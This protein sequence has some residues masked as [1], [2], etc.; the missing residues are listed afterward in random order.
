[1]AF[2][3]VATG[4]VEIKQNALQL[5][6]CFASGRF[7]IN[8]VGTSD[9]AIQC[10]FNPRMVDMWKHD[11]AGVVNRYRWIDGMPIA[12]LTHDPDD[13]TGDSY[14]LMVDSGT[15]TYLPLAGGGFFDGV[16]SLN[17]GPKECGYRTPYGW[18]GT[19]YTGGVE[20]A[21]KGTFFVVWR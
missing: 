8:A 20:T 12:A 19:S 21:G 14:F 13:F 18:V 10:G 6:S 11:G 7:S 1:M 9:F 4:N 16:V 17:I 3:S 5:Q 15:I 2:K